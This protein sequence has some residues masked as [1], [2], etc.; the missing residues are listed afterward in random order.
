[1]VDGCQGILDQIL[2]I[3]TWLIWSMVVTDRG[4]DGSMNK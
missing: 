2:E 4:I 1:M 3:L